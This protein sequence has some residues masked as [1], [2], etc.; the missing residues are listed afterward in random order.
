MLNLD[1]LD[2]A[3]AAVPIGMRDKGAIASAIRAYLDACGVAYPHAM[4][5][6]VSLAEDSSGNFR[7]YCGCEAPTL[8]GTIDSAIHRVNS[9]ASTQVEA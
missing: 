1:G 7:V 9:Y 4:R 3:Y 8:H 2:A 5:H 6:I